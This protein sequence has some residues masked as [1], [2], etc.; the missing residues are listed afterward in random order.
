MPS[1]YPRLITFVNV[2]LYAPA[3]AAKF[4]DGSSPEPMF[5]NA[6]DQPKKFDRTQGK[7]LPV[8]FYSRSM[9]LKAE[10]SSVS[11]QCGSIAL[12]S[13]DQRSLS[14]FLRGLE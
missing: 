6:A 8:A 14:E 1:P 13:G 2:D 5:T 9:L 12:Q 7:V 3:K 11:D 10:S 4:D